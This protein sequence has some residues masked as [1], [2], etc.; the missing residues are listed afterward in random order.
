M[1]SA[2]STKE[3][4]AARETYLKQRVLPF[5]AG[6]FETYPALRSCVMSVAQYWCDEALDAVHYDFIW[7]ELET[8]NVEAGM[9]V[10]YEERDAA[11]L[12]TIGV[13]KTDFLREWDDNGGSISLFAAYCKEG[14]DQEMVKAEAHLPF[15]VF[16]REEKGVSYRIAPVQR[17]P[18]LD[19]VNPIWNDDDIAP[20]D[21]FAALYESPDS[22]APNEDKTRWWEVKANS[23]N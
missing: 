9:V 1:S 11:N 21:A 18:W 13:V 19:G 17:R 12:P 16:R 22:P 15:A 6:V 3:A 14:C 5:V 4:A 8:P 10:E 2:M 23:R 7:S 20:D